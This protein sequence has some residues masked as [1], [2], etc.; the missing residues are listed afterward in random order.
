[1]SWVLMSG[2]RQNR[3]AREPAPYFPGLKRNGRTSVVCGLMPLFEHHCLTTALNQETRR[4]RAFG[5]VYSNVLARCGYASEIPCGVEVRRLR[6]RSAGCANNEFFNLV[7]T[8]AEGTESPHVIFEDF[9]FGLRRGV[10]EF[11]GE[12]G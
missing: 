4:V 12:L 3:L 10:M 11:I 7:R 2:S 5:F 6:I 9:K 8:I 1:M